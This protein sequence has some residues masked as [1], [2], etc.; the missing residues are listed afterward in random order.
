MTGDITNSVRNSDRPTS[1]WLGGV[2]VVPSAWRISDSTMMMRVKLVIIS[3]IAGRN[4]SIASTS[5]VCTLSEYVVL[6]FGPG[7]AFRAGRPD[8]CAKDRV[9]SASNSAGNS[10]VARVRCRRAEASSRA[11][12]FNM[13]G[14]AVVGAA[15]A[16][17]V[18]AV[19]AA[20][21]A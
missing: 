11:K 17:G 1:T 5:I 3:T 21:K 16:T 8:T 20:V 4:D 13:Q 7:V 10:S 2:V 15:V 6:P 12:D 18:A 14:N 19:N 9:G